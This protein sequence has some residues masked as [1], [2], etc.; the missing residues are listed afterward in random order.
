[1]WTGVRERILALA[2]GPEPEAVFGF[3]GHGF[4]LADRLTPG[5][6]A[7][8][9]AW[10][11]IRLPEEYRGF[12]LEVGAGG[13]GPC[14][15][16]FT[17]ARDPGGFWRWHGDGAEMITL[18]RLAE[19]FPRTHPHPEAVAALA[20]EEPATGDFADID[21]FLGAHGAW[22][23][24]MEKLE[25][26]ED[27]TVGAL[28]LCHRGCALRQWLVVSGPEAGRMWDD[29]RVDEEDMHPATGA[30][31]GPVG[32]ARWYLDWL[33]WAEEQVAAAARG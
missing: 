16:V 1:M 7:E 26:H 13:A 33:E 12:L 32:F 30:D 28:C 2:A 20:A 10:L 15:G 19:P 18:S 23:L 31:G 17:V 6:L 14:Y 5:E 4:D 9:E 25:F 29:V 22:D 27:R 3:A 11:G 8:L 24:T 21:A